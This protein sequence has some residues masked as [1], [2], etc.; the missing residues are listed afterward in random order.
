M[1]PV[2]V[3][4]V[5]FQVG[6]LVTLLE[7]SRQRNVAAAINAL[8]AL[9]VA[10]LPWALAL[11]VDPVLPLWLG[12]AG[13]LHAVGMLGPYDTVRWWDHLTHFVSASLVA[14]LVHAG[15]VVGYGDTT[16][17]AS[18]A[19]ATVLFTFAAGLFWELV[20]LGARELGDRFDIEPVL[21][22]YGWRDTILD[23]GFDLAGAALVVVLDLR[24]FVPVAEQVVGPTRRPALR[25]VVAVVAG[26]VLLTLVLLASRI[27]R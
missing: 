25:G 3:A 10:L 24:T 4:A 8:V 7:S 9:V 20:E 11:A 6:I 22:H 15:L 21:V 5:A 27:D 17:A 18:V 16:T 23:L 13:L 1:N 2:S 26:T 14:A 12:V 19:I